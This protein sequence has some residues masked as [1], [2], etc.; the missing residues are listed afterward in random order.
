MKKLTALL[1]AL[2]LALP[3]AVNA[4]PSYSDTAGSSYEKYVSF[5]TALGFMEGYHDGTFHPDGVNDTCRVCSV[6]SASARHGRRGCGSTNTV[7]GRERR[8]LGKQRDCQ[9]C[10]FRHF[11]RDIR[12][13]ISIRKKTSP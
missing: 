2:C 10:R 5:A 7:S 9:R 12:T 6:G 11:E 13:D 1:L 3:A 4:A 8:T